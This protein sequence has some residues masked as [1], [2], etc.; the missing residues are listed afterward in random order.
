M[1]TKELFLQTTPGPSP[2]P[3]EL[4]IRID[5]PHEFHFYAQGL[6]AVDFSSVFENELRPL[7]A[8]VTRM[9]PDLLN[10]NYWEPLTKESENAVREKMVGIITKTEGDRALLWRSDRIAR[11]RL[12]REGLELPVQLLH[13]YIFRVSGESLIKLAQAKEAQA[14]FEWAA[15]AP[16]P[17]EVPSELLSSIHGDLAQGRR[18][19]PEETFLFSSHE[20]GLSRVVFSSRPH[21]RRAIEALVRGFVYGARPRHLGWISARTCDQ[22]ANLADG[23]GL[24]ATADRELVDTGRTLEIHGDL[25]R[26]PWGVALKPGQE[27]LVGDEKILIYYDSISGLWAVST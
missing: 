16:L 21:L 5:G 17:A 23:V 12:L 1:N 4:F 25:G 6:T 22:I 8:L 14:R 27:P 2:H 24:S 3:L 7:E 18:S 11:S 15:V 9:P 13:G 10:P 26:T 19:L 20:D